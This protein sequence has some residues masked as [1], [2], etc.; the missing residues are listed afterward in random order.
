LART[1][2]EKHIP[3]LVLVDA[4]RRNQPI[5]PNVRVAA[6]FYQRDSRP[7]CGAA[8]IR[9]ENPK[10][11]KILG[12]FQW[13]C[14]HKYVDIQ[15]EPWVRNFFVRGHEKMEFDPNMLTT[16]KKIRLDAVAL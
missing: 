10:I 13:K 3:V 4:I 2:N 9:A 6:N 16:L 11:T 5:P 1:L 12:N 8:H 14:R 7:V 15:R